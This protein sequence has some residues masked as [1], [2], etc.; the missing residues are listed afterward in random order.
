MKRILFSVIVISVISFSCKKEDVKIET[1]K[2]TID[3]AVDSIKISQSEE[4]VDTETENIKSD[5]DYEEVGEKD[6][7]K[8]KGEYFLDYIDYAGEN[9]G[10]KLKVKLVLDSYQDG[11][12][13]LWYEKPNDTIKEGMHHVFG[14]FGKADKENNTIKFLPEIITEG[15]DT[16]IDLDYFLYSRN[17]KFYIKSGM[18]PSENGDSREIPIQK[19]K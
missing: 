1:N 8:W 13:Y 15:E 17:G 14:S 7:A 4:S 12:F 9:D 11:N 16:G 6:F 10:T 3:K 2:A 19:I 5:L 18:I